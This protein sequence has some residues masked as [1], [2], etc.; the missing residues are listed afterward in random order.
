MFETKTAVGKVHPGLDVGKRFSDT[1]WAFEDALVTG[2]EPIESEIVLPDLDDRHVVAAAVH[3]R[4][5]AIITA[6]VSDFPKPSGTFGT[7]EQSRSPGLCRRDLAP[8]A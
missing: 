3:G 1:H 8:H 5:Q 6:N 2:W 4:A 7:A